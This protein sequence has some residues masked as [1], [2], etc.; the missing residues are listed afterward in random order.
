MKTGSSKHLLRVSGLLTAW[1]WVA[2]AAGAQT[3]GNTVTEAAARNASDRSAQIWL[4][5]GVVGFSVA[6]MQD[7]K[8]V[9]EKSYGR[10]S[11][12]LD[13]P[14]PTRAVYE[15]AS[16][17]KPFTAA[18]VLRLVDEGKLKL[19]DA[20]YKY[21]PDALAPGL[22]ERVTLRQMLSHTSG[23]PDY[24]NLEGYAALAT[25]ETP[26]EAIL[27]LLKDSPPLFEPGA[28]QAYSNSGYLL[29]GLVIKK[30]TGA[31]WGDYIEKEIFAPLGMADS[32]ASLN[33]EIVPGMATPYEYDGKML[34][35]APYHA[36]EVIHGNAGLRSSARDMARWVDA[37]HT[38]KVLP[39]N[40]YREMM[41]PGRLPD[42]THLRY[43]L[44]MVV[45][46]AL[47][48]P[49]YRHGG[50]FPGFMSHAA[51]LPGK[52]LAIAVLTNTTGPFGED[53]IAREIL[54]PL[55]GDERKTPVVKTVDLAPYVGEYVAR[56]RSQ[57]LLKVTIK[58]GRLVAMVE[59]WDLGPREFVAVGNDR[60]SSE[61]FD[62]QFLRK[63]GRVSGVVRSG[64]VSVV[65]FD[66]K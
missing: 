1:L 2:A 40:L 28:A 27:G 35:K 18:A 6:V 36:F 62:L 34:T 24:T 55:I 43:G 23:I 53:E 7:G 63:N 47:G 21:L 12:E 31:S 57:R 5:K 42:G 46:N 25:Q 22:A 20:L 29:L 65:P 59:P 60:F 45:G 38:S 17:A 3:P 15:I 64:E 11:V 44:G 41:T 52:K 26:A 4:A 50:T 10:A 56:V 33:R 32:R 13:V 30:V 16:D 48:H 54:S 19:D 8:L 14:M 61:F 51:Y 39:A 9:F 37:L 58:D 49:V 66:R